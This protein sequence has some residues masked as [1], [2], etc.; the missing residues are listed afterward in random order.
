MKLS[1][2]ALLLPAASLA[3]T[4][5]SVP[6]PATRSPL[7]RPVPLNNEF[8]QACESITSTTE[9][10]VGKADDLV[11]SRVMRLVDH[12][13]MLYTLKALTDKAGISASLSGITSNPSAF[14]GLSTALAVPTWCFHVWT[15][16]AICQVA[17]VA[18]SVLAS[19]S[20]ELS[21]ADIT[22]NT[23]ANLAAARLIGS[24]NPLRDTILSAV[25]SGYALRQGDAAGSV[26][27]HNAGV[28]LMSSFTTVL[29][30]LGLVSTVSAR[31][32][33][34]KDQAT[35]ISWLGVAAYYALATREDNGTVKKAVTAG[36]AAG[37]VVSTIAGGVNLM[38]FNLPSVF[39]NIGV[40][41]LAYVAYNS[42]NRLRQAVFD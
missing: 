18:K 29:A 10:Y 4:P 23:A 12:A 39:T 32:P 8:D 20:N 42:V 26:N 36:I 24:S 38:S 2:I 25:V 16:I 22:A 13:P 11:L 19:D 5:V 37:M 15:L 3:F 28:Q 9:D 33:V 30:V 1:L 27:I 34:L 21:Q 17:S 6:S 35:I 41:G 40:L 14:G 31:I 7:F